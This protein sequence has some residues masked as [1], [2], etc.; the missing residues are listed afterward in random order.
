[1]GAGASLEDWSEAEHVL[2]GLSRCP[3]GERSWTQDDALI[4]LWGEGSGALS[5]AAWDAGQERWSQPVAF[6]FRFQDPLTGSPMSLRDLHAAPTEGT[7]SVVGSEPAGGEVW[8]TLAEVDVLELAAAPTPTLLGLI[9]PVEPEPEPEGDAPAWGAPVNLSQSGAAEQP[10]I[11][12]GP[13]GTLQVFWWDRF[14]GLMTALFNGET[15]STPTRATIPVVQAAEREGE[16]VAGTLVVPVVPTIVS[17]GSG[18]VHAF[19]LGEPDEDTG[20]QAL[21]HSQMPLGTTTWC[22]QRRWPSRRWP[23]TWR[24]GRRER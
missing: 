14:D 21:M 18:W 11:V 22:R 9:G 1:M 2:K 3:E 5:L 19:W 4:W 8:A 16:A 15:R 10:R 17:D 24:G 20:V 13:D 23:L 6:D 7:L 12:A